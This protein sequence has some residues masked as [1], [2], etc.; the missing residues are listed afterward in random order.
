EHGVA[1]KL[2]PT[3]KYFPVSDSARDV[4]AG[5]LRAVEAAGGELRSEG[6]VTGAHFEDDRFRLDTSAGPIDASA[7]VLCTGGLS[8]PETG[9][10][11]TGYDLARAF[12]HSI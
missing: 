7:V 1:L 10:D 9:S 8:Y 12:G 11:G 3:G 5:L 2:E 4:L 6:L